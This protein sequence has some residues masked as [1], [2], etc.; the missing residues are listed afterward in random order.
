MKQPL[1]SLGLSSLFRICACLFLLAAIIGPVRG[2]E[3]KWPPMSKELIERIENLPRERVVVHEEANLQSVEDGVA[4]SGDVHLIDH[5][6]PLLIVLIG[7]AENL[8]QKE[9]GEHYEEVMRVVSTL[10]QANFEAAEG[11]L[12]AAG[13]EYV[14]P[15]AVAT[16]NLLAHYARLVMMPGHWDVEDLSQWQERWSGVAAEDTSPGAAEEVAASEDEER[17]ALTGD[18]VAT[19]E[20]EMFASAGITPRRMVLVWQEKKTSP[21]QRYSFNLHRITDGKIYAGPDDV[22][23][24]YLLY[25]DEEGR[26]MLNIEL[27]SEDPNL[28]RFELEMVRDEE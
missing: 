28:V 25:R 18:W 5:W 19:A 17:V 22:G 20:S 27:R 23:L 9:A 24:A 4:S 15:A 12:T 13:G 11:V 10:T 6:K 7:R 3:S 26:E 14:R 21:V 2:Q 8:D 1:R 16:E